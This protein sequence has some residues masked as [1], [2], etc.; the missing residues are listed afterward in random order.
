M[1]A[2]ACLLVLGKD[3]GIS[4]AISLSPYLP[5]FAPPPRL[6]FSFSLLFLLLSKTFQCG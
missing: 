4:Q 5:P 1:T 6:T 2:V 3:A